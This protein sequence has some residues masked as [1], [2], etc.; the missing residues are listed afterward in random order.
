MLVPKCPLNRGS[1]VHA[2]KTLMQSWKMCPSV[3]WILHTLKLH[4]KKI[5]LII[6]NNN[7]KLELSENGTINIVDL[8]LF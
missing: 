2:L 5:N 1:T 4:I 8:I 7:L 6:M 3:A